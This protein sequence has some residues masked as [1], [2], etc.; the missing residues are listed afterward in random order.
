V[1]VVWTAGGVAI[2]PAKLFVV[3][4]NS[5]YFSCLQLDTV[6][7]CDFAHEQV[8]AGGWMCSKAMQLKICYS[9]FAS[10]Q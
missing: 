4:F 2:P 3:D 7:F 9:L 6:D 8:W 5:R 1:L 10:H